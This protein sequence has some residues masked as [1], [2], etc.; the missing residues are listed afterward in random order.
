MSQMF[1]SGSESAAYGAKLARVQVVSAY[2]I[3]PNVT[4]IGTLS[5]MIESGELDAEFVNVEGEHSAASV[6]SGAAA[7][8]SRAFTS[9]CGQ[10]IAF[11]HEV[12]WMASGMA[13]PIVIAVT[14]RGIGIPQTLAC[15]FSDIASER[16]ASF[17]HFYTENAQEVVDSVI[18][19]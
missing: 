18:M 5:E 2:P 8:G 13:L 10:G 3:S 16:D 4:V 6:I 19:A 11:M 12:L 17:L 7:A 15:D 14:S 1:L 9:S